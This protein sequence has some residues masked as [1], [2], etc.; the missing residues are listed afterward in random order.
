MV[1]KN[2]II[3]LL[4]SLMNKK[5]SFLNDSYNGFDMSDQNTKADTILI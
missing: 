2:T 3:L 5:I 4:N 1:V